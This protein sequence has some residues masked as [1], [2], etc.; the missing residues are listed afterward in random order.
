[1]DIIKKYH[2]RLLAEWEKDKRCD[3]EEG[4]C[5]TWGIFTVIMIIIALVIDTAL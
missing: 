2:K 3:L 4:D 5:I 1:M